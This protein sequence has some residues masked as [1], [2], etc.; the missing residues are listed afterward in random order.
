MN[1]SDADASEERRTAP[2][3]ADGLDLA[4]VEAL[5]A[6]DADAL[7]CVCDAGGVLDLLAR[8]HAIA[9]VCAVGALEPARYGDVEDA[10]ADAS[11]STLSARFED[12]V[13]AGVLAR[14]QYDEIPPRVEY[15]LTDDGHAL[16]DA[17]GPLVQWVRERDGEA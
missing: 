10:L 1:R 13:D 8:R 6:A 4:D 5:D 9:V 16:Y 15:E 2:T 17:L 11:S 12:L 3:D 14:E 7:A